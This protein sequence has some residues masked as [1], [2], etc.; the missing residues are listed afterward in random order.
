MTVGKSALKK[1]ALIINTRSRKGE[2]FFFEILELL[3]KNGIVVESSYPV[4]NSVFLQR[5]VKEAIAKGPK[6]VIVGGG[7]GTLSS[8]VQHFAY[9][10]IVLGVLPLGTGNSFARSL[11][12][13]LD[14]SG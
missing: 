4:S 14:I 5:A 2:E 12:L 6:L 1:A 13:P 3:E 9:K 8:V 11:E 10:S 7:D